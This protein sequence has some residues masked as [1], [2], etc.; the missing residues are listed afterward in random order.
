MIKLI[1]LL[2]Y[3]YIIRRAWKKFMRQFAILKKKIYN[4]FPG[5]FQQAMVNLSFYNSNI[6]KQLYNLKLMMIINV[7]YSTSYILL[8]YIIITNI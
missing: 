1:L 8:I 5:Y 2:K 6:C 7:M 3:L 4:F